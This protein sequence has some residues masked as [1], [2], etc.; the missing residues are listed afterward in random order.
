MDTQGQAPPEKPI[1]CLARQP[2]LTRDEKVLGYELLF[3]DSPDD[4]HAHSDV[5]SG[6]N[7]IIDTL[8]VV[9]F[10]AVCDGR[11]AFINLWPCWSA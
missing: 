8:N 1:P 6:T 9:G 11:L 10:D 4:R 5:E 7:S 3:R 2:I